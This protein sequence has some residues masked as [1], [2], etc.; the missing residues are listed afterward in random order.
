MTKTLY[1]LDANVFVEAKK[2]YYA[3]D[4]CPGFW[5]SLTWHYGQGNVC[6]VDRVRSELVEHGDEL[7]DWVANQMPAAAFHSTKEDT[8]AA[9][10]GDVVRWAM[11]QPQFMDA[12][13]AEFADA[14]VA[15]AWLVAYASTRGATL[16]THE[17]FDDHIRRKVK[18]PNVCRAFHVPYLDT[19]H[20]L[21]QLGIQFTWKAS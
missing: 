19:F 1:V 6:S 16:V 12:A 17:T 11:N 7:S 14:K 10:Y 13:K 20:M 8:I 21:A 5:N 15:D 18:I 9:C 3:F 4:I 2:R